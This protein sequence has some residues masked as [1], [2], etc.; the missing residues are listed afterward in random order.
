[1]YVLFVPSMILIKTRSNISVRTFPIPTVPKL[2]LR[3]TAVVIGGQSSGKS[4]LLNSI[5]SADILPLGEQM[6][7][8]T[9]L[10]L[11]L[12]NNPDG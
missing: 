2:I 6:V 3:F 5:M 10:H 9:P 4:S 8:R 12:V 7:T 11:Q 1:M